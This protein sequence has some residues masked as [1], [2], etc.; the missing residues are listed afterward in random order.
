M[1]CE[2]VKEITEAQFEAE[3]LQSPIPVVVDFYSEG[4][5]PCQMMAP[6]MEQLCAEFADAIKFV[7]LDIYANRIIARR[8]HIEAAPTF[9]VYRNGL[10]LSQSR[11]AQNKRKFTD[12]IQTSLAI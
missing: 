8:H 5:Q 12:W 4:C 2:C 1:V 9:F 11:G 10:I 6:T 3:V 7:K